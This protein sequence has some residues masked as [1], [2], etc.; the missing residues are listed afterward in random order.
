MSLQDQVNSDIKNAMKAREKEKLEALR[1]LKSLFIKNNTSP[2]PTDDQSIVI[3]HAKKLKDS[4]EHYPTGTDAHN[5]IVTE[6]DFLSPYLPKPMSEED[7]KK[8]ISD[9]ISSMPNAQMGPVMGKISKEIKGKFDGKRATELVK[10]M[11]QS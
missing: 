7:V 11:L 5:K 4:L 6:V 1:F 2:K 9:A 8:L 3:S 10:E